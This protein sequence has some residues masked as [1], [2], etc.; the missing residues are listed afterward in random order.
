MSSYRNMGRGKRRH[1]PMK[2]KTIYGPAKDQQLAAEVSQ[3]SVPAARAS[4]E[5][6][7]KDFRAAK[8]RPH[9][10]KIL[11]ATQLEA[12]R[13]RADLRRQDLHADT[14]ARLENEAGIY[15]R[16]SDRM[17]EDLGDK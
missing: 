13:L 7:E 8:T 15:E 14:R 6:L 9:K 10:V 5:K 3:T 17:Q 2:G 4:A 12:N 11:R 1:T 16:A